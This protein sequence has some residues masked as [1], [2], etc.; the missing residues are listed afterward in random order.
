MISQGTTPILRTYRDQ[1]ETFGVPKRYWNETLVGDPWSRLASVRSWFGAWCSGQ[2]YGNSSSRMSGAGLTVCGESGDSSRLVAGLVQDVLR[3]KETRA[4]VPP[5]TRTL[6]W[7]PAS[8]MHEMLRDSDWEDRLSHSD[9][10]KVAILVVTDVS[11][12]E[13]WETQTV[14]K[15]LR[16]RFQNGSP[17]FVTVRPPALKSMSTGLTSLLSEMNALEAL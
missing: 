15:V 8:A 2:V 14:E 10:S 6:R 4:L 13:R 3:R 5:S 11:P 12:E 7:Y 1:L 16:L 9:L 17:T